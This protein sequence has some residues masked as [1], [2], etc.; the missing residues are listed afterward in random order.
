MGLGGGFVTVLF[1]GYWARAYG[2]RQLGQIQGVAQ[3]LTVL[4]SAAGPLLLAQW[5][6][7]TGSYGSMFTLMAIVVTVNAVAALAVRMPNPEDAPVA[8]VQ[9]SA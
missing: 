4:A 1:F 7:R 8:L 3:A 2:R 5:V 6:A 9:E